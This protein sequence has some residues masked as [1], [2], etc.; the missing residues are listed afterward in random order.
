MNHC[1]LCLKIRRWTFYETIKYILQ[2]YSTPRTFANTKYDAATKYDIEVVENWL[3][4]LSNYKSA[5][6]IEKMNCL[7]LGPGADLGVGLYL[8]S[9]G[10][11][12]YNS[13]DLSHFLL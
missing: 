10:I 4:Y 5:A 11:D 12:K 1:M 13:F 8:L 9:K 2:G 3:S 7:E 6:S